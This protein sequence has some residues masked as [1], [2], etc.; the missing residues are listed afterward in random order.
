VRLRG[1]LQRHKGE[2]H[3]PLLCRQQ[4]CKCSF[5]NIFNLLRH[6]NMYHSSPDDDAGV[7]DESS[8]LQT[9]SDEMVQDCNNDDAPCVAAGS[10][11]D[12][13]VNVVRDISAEGVSL[14][15]SLRANSSVPYNVIPNI[16]ESFNQ[17]A[18]SLS[19]FVQG[20]TVDCLKAAGVSSDL[21]ETV[22]TKL[23]HRLRE[24]A[25]ICKVKGWKKEIFNRNAL[26]KK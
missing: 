13:D 12:C 23:E 20:E 9:Y 11:V 4:N 6:V 16:V 21:V 10:E 3:Y 8:F 22:K 19:T 18:G 15:A 24:C 7:V 14:V 5:Q 25:V 26:Q 17:M 2:L 1:H